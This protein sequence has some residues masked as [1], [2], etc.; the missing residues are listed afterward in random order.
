MALLVVG[1]V[2]LDSVRTPFGER[3]EVLGG[4]AT[5][6]SVAASYFT[7]VNVVAVVGEDFTD[8]QRRI[9]AGR[10]IDL[11]GLQTVSGRTFRW[12]GEY[13]GNLNVARTVETQ[14]NVF[15]GFR[16]TLP[17]AYRESDYVFLANIDPDLQQEVLAQ[18]RSP[19]LIAADTM[20]FWIG[21]KRDVLVETLRNVDLLFVN[22]AEARDLSGEGNL[23]TSAMVIRAMGPEVVV[24]KRGEH[25][26]M[27]FARDGV[28]MTPAY[29]LEKPLDPTGAG[30]VTGPAMRRAMVFGS[31]M[32]SFA[33][34]D[35]SLG[36]LSR[37]TEEEV[38]ERYRAFSRMTE[39]EPLP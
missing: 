24:I 10:R 23:V 35:F 5:Y 12:R 15:G 1:S 38:R 30:S 20:N 29:P 19:R 37:L 22:D 7:D 17:P 26:A 16:P 27:M 25:G 32:A 2:A 28:F 3:Q 14:L 21:G 9:F 6:C 4:S 39:F 18:V 33:V 8:E 31:V 36:R 11:S 13:S 34:E